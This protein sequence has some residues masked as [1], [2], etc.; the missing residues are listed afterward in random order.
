MSGAALNLI[1][2]LAAGASAH[3]AQIAEL[4]RQVEA[5]E[6]EQAKESAIVLLASDELSDEERVQVALLSGTV[7]RILGHDLEAEQHYLIALRLNPDADL[8]ESKGPKIDVFFAEVKNTFLRE[9]SLL[10]KPT[11]PAVASPPA[12]MQSDEAVDPLVLSGAGLAAVSAAAALVSG[13]GAVVLHLGFVANKGASL[14]AR[15]AARLG[16]YASL[17]AALV[18]VLGCGTGGV[19]AG[20]ALIRE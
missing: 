11:A 19:L 10:E 18:A 17:A 14:Q 20:Y 5:L 7:N 1:L 4:E 3:S 9:Q 2:V 13:V 12:A 6:Y 16:V 8:G 15:E